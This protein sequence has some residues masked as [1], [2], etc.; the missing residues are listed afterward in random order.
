MIREI[1]NKCFFLASVNNILNLP[2]DLLCEVGFWGKSNVGKSSLLNAIT[3]TKIARTSKTPG[4]TTSL[5]FFEIKN[6]IRL[7][8]F[9]GYG[10]AVRSKKEIYDWNE[11]I[12][13]YL[14]ERNNVIFIFLL[15]DSRH[16]LKENDKEAIKLME[17]F[18][19]KYHIVLTKIDK[20]NKKKLYEYYEE[21]EN[22]IKN[23]SK[24][25]KTIFLTSSK[26][27]I[28]IKELEK[29]IIEVM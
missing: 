7:V 19:K 26:K 3:N 5:N 27:N 10:F 9:P 1:K 29:F 14:E 18:K 28:G 25:N 17:T 12:V 8:D 15:I 16:G 11:L 22:Y 6:K 20:I 2:D 21:I 4:R 23:K 24:N 13:N